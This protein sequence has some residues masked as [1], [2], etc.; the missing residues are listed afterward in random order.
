MIYPENKIYFD[1]SHYIAIPHT[2]GKKRRQKDPEEKVEVIE[3]SKN[4]PNSINPDSAELQ[5]IVPTF[6]EDEKT[7][8]KATRSEIFSDVYAEALDLPKQHR[9][10]YV[11]DNMRPYFKTEQDLDE[12]INEKVAMK[13]RNILQRKT[14][15]IRKAYM[16]DF[17]YFATFT[18][19]NKKLDEMSFKKQL[20]KCLSNYQ[21]RKGWR[22]M[23]VWE[24]APHT[25]RLHFHCLLYVPKGTMPGE[26]IKVR[27]FNKKTFRMQETTQN[28]FFNER[29]GRSDFEEID[30]SLLK[31]GQSLVYILKYIE[32]SGEKIVYSRG[33]PMYFISDINDKDILCYYG[34]EDKKMILAD[35]FTCYDYG[36]EL[37]PISPK[38]MKLLRKTNN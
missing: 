1:G 26:L 15:F 30:D 31:M 14:R 9:K 6:F 3:R 25:K 10:E 5:K 37:G 23:G 27:D 34:I 29:F 38:I 13:R 36:E 7:P 21:S 35:G 20:S 4:P 28:T 18:Y 19:D 11:K 8:Q 2:E 22:Y 32:K 17:N 33:L 12:F 16:N 24:R